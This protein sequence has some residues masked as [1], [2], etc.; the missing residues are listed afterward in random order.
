MY[1]GSI[2]IRD[3]VL[4]WDDPYST[5][6]IMSILYG[7]FFG[8]MALGFGAPNFKTIAEGKMNGYQALKV[9]NW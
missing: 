8:L 2:L 7:V 1:V 5:G 9:I 3:K 6:D 4:N